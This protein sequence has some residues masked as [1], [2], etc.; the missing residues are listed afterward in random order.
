[1]T[2][3]KSVPSMKLRRGIGV[4]QNSAWFPGQRLRAALS[5]EGDLF[6]GLAQV[7]ETHFGGLLKLLCGSST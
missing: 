6:A 4:S 1:M 3:L 7:D 5:R 2:S